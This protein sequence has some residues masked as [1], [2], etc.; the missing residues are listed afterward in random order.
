MLKLKKKTCSARSSRLTLFAILSLFFIDNFG[1][2][3]VYPIF[4]PLI[5]LSDY[6]FSTPM[7]SSELKTFMLG[8]LILS[9]PLAQLLSAPI[10]GNL[11]D[12]YGRKRAFFFT[13]IGEVIGYF[14]SGISIEIKSYSLLIFSRL[15]TGFFAGNLIICLSSMSDICK[16]EGKRSKYFGL[17]ALTGALSFILAILTGG[18]F[19]DRLINPRF[20]SAL[21]FWITTALAL[22]NL[23]IIFRFYKE[24]H[25]EN[26][27]HK[28]SIKHF[29]NQ[30]LVFFRLKKIYLPTLSYFF[31]ILGWIS[32]IQFLS[33]LVINDYGGNKK[34]V[35][36]LFLGI[37]IVWIIGNGLINLFLQKILKPYT[38]AIL[39]LFF[40]TLLYF[41]ISLKPSFQVFVS[42]Y[43][44]ASLFASI[45][46]TNLVASISLNANKACQGKLLGF[47]QGIATLA[48]VLSPLIAVNL[49]A[50]D[51]I[52]LYYLVTA[53][54]FFSFICIF[55]SFMLS[56]RLKY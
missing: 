2:A 31:F 56:R 18:A 26:D 44:F 17:L 23:Y 50:F 38:L 8:F 51:P 54:L 19:S 42:F 15:L 52:T 30:Y 1:M 46:W 40:T 10:I 25:N 39:T 36:A 45:S 21:P 13:L 43:L 22:L 7:M 14:L 53:A 28:T 27:R 41:F 9:F 4:T 49:L 32:S 35:T 47:N 20:N 6:G 5:L 11:A 29:F 12:I 48:V 33:L 37:G 3:L 34:T 55:L 16:S 24:T